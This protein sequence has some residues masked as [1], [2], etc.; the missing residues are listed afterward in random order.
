MPLPESLALDRDPCAFAERWGI[1]VDLGG[2][3]LLLARVIIQ[4]P[5]LKQLIRTVDSIKMISGFRSKESQDALRRQGRPAADD[6]KSTHRSC[7]ATGADVRLEGLMDPTTSAE[8]REAW[9]SIGQIAT[10][11]GLRWGGGSPV[12]PSTGL[13]VDFNHFDLGPRQ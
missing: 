9:Q 1:R 11:I 5:R 13:P 6:E 4:D 8:A 7:P 2:L 3:L 10:R 12:D